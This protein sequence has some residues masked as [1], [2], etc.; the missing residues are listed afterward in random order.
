VT[1]ADVQP[2]IALVD[3]LRINL[4]VASEEPLSEIYVDLV[5]DGLPGWSYSS[6]HLDTVRALDL[7][8]LVRGSFNLVV[9]A[10]TTRGCSVQVD[11]GVVKV[12]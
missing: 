11:K 9:S 3:P 4:T 12:Q 5:G 6:A 1:V 2:Q 7:R 10:W 8:P